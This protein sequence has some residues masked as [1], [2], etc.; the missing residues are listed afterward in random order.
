MGLYL[1][2]L[3]DEARAP[4]REHVRRGFLWNRPDG[5][6]SFAATAWGVVEP[7]CPRRAR[8]VA[9]LAVTARKAFETCEQC[10]GASNLGIGGDPDGPEAVVDGWVVVVMPRWGY[11]S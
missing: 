4:L 2:A 10:S 11:P 6:R 1:A 9:Q 5:P 7:C 3:S 8:R